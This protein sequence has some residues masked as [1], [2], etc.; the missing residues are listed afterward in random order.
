MGITEKEAEER[1]RKDG[2]NVIGEERRAGPLRIFLG[3]FRD[4]MVMILLGG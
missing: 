1:L 4:V 2:E 3:Q